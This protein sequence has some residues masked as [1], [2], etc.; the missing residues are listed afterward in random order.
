MPNSTGQRR[1]LGSRSAASKVSNRPLPVNRPLTR[2]RPATI[3]S[4]APIRHS[5]SADDNRAGART[6][7]RTNHLTRPRTTKAART[8]QPTTG[9]SAPRTIKAKNHECLICYNLFDLT[10]TLMRQPT[11]SCAHEVNI[12][13]PC[14]SASISSQLEAKLWTRISC[15]SSACEEL[16]EY[17]D[18][19]EFAESQTFAR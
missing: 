3:N 14:L 2:N 1:T 12:C 9:P 17:G 16:L 10:E 4:R 18:I 15:P 7:S 8:T 11:S 6:Q 19:Q 13:K 5:T